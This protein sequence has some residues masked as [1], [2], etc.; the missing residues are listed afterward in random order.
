MTRRIA[1]LASGRGSNLR[2][3][4]EAQ[5]EGHLRSGRIV[6][7]VSNVPG[8][9]ALAIAE[10][11][12]I[13]AIAVD[14]R[15]FAK[16]RAA[17]ERAI[18]AAL[19]PHRAELLVLAGYMR[20]LEGPL[21]DR[22]AGAMLNIHPSLLPAFRGIHAQRQAVQARVAVAGCT[23][24]L[25]TR[26]VDE[27]PILAQRPVPAFPHDTE[28]TL[29]AR[30]LRE[31]HALLPAAVEAFA[32]GAWDAAAPRPALL[33]ATGNAHKV[34]EI[35]AILDGC[36]LALRTTREFPGHGDV[37]EPA[38]DYA[39][40]ALIKARAWRERTG[41]ATL[42][43]D[44][45]LEVD[46]LGGRPGVHSARY[47]PTADERITKLLRELEGTP[48]ARR[49]ARFVCVAALSLPDGSELTARGVCEG[50]IAFAPSGHG[51]FGYDPVFVPEGFGGRHLAELS[52]DTKNRI[53]H[54]ARALALLRPTI[55]RVAA[56]WWR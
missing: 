15:P 42:S 17:H 53:S 48:E 51:G 20:V 9:G 43:D 8:A 55:E 22:F 54:R 4:L 44:S 29:A 50:R 30:I 33:L 16:D 18:I 47:A 12:G 32:R 34:E 28:E 52:A 38:P 13:P 5:A 41:L 40:N 26:G 49:T 6:A 45:G 46:A 2:A 36:G 37:E 11:H 27:G 14:H 56:E 23:V 1:V 25:V 10:S 7:V 35:G 21:L 19:E 39:G 24:H 3:L 31:E